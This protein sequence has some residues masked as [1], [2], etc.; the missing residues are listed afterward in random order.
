M[1]KLI[2]YLTKRMASLVLPFALLSAA[3]FP[4]LAQAEGELMLDRGGLD[5]QEGDPLDGNEPDGDP[6]GGDDIH[7]TTGTLDSRRGFFSLILRSTRVLLVPQY[8]GSTLTF[9][10]IFLAEAIDVVER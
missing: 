1:E 10:I 4:C 9:K 6:T 5:R 7:D 3:F 8:N 2:E